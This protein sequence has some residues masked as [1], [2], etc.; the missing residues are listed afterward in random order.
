MIA[1]AVPILFGAW[2]GTRLVPML[3]T[4]ET[5]FSSW[6]GFLEGFFTTAGAWYG[7]FVGGVTGLLC[8]C[9]RR[10][11]SPGALLDALAPAI[12][13]AQAVGRGACFLAGCDHGRESQ[14]VFAVSFTH[15]GS[16]VSEDLRGVPLH[17]VQLYEAAACLLLAL[18]VLVV[19][20][21][22]RAWRLPLRPGALF[23]LYSA[24]YA[25]ARVVLETFRGDGERGLWL[26]GAVSTSQILATFVLAAVLVFALGT[27]RKVG[28]RHPSTQQGK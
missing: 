22:V 2:L 28:A 16:A 8:F 27:K 7:G 19:E 4:P 3:V 5:V 25:I 13:L 10:G 12:P 26:G 1:A 21:R 18:L 6:R 9:R 14:S 11:I 20:R 24:S 15:P 23:A 17:P